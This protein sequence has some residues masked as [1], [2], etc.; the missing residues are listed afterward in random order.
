MVSHQLYHYKSNI[1]FYTPFVLIEAGKS[2][3]FSFKFS[4]FTRKSDQAQIQLFLEDRN[5]NL[6][7]LEE[8]QVVSTVSGL[9]QM[10]SF[11]FKDSKLK[12]VYRIFAKFKG[13]Q[14]RSKISVD[15]IYYDGQFI[16]CRSKK[17][18][19]VNT[20]D[21]DFYPDKKEITSKLN[22]SFSGFVKEKTELYPNP[23]NG[24]FILEASL[25]GHSKLTVYDVLGKEIWT[26]CFSTNE[27]QKEHQI[28]IND[29]AQGLYF[30]KIETANQTSIQRFQIK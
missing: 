5:E 29:Q 9:V 21:E 12:G 20:I 8:Y 3:S 16:G 13:E 10:Y 18:A 22:E 11:N 19:F 26:K 23:N 4:G 27:V 14:C 1:G 28:E 30:L 25:S 24:K 7:E 2:F 15:N 6:K 17:A